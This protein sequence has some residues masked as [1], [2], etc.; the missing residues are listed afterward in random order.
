MSQALC[1]LWS[2]SAVATRHEGHSLGGAQSLR[3]NSN[4][5]SADQSLTTTLRMT[6]TGVSGDS[7]C[8]VPTPRGF[9]SG[10]LVV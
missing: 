10:L 1:Q 7:P 2:E 3:A 4:A 8:D 6:S 9:P 5:R